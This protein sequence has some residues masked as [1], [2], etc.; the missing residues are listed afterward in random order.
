MIT[1]VKSLVIGRGLIS[2][3]GKLGWRCI[4]S[5]EVK[6]QQEIG[7]GIRSQLSKVFLH[8]H[9][10]PNVLERNVVFPLLSN[11]HCLNPLALLIRKPTWMS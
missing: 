3:L 4:Q 10:S 11:L 6:P 9:L 7:F 1:Y 5:Q 8:R 2:F